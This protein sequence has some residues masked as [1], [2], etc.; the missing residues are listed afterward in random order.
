MAW[1]ASTG[2]FLVWGSTIDTNFEDGG[3]HVAQ[4][5]IVD[6]KYIFL[7]VVGFTRG[8]HVEAQASI[9][10]KLNEIVRHVLDVSLKVP[11][12]DCILIPTGGGICIVLLGRD[13]PY[14]AHVQVA[15]G[16]LARLD[17]HNENTADEMLRFEVRVGLNENR[18]NEI[19][20]ING[21][22]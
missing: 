16:I 4:A 20:D 19:T 1:S 14:D 11:E 5:N 2:A 12:N 18:D 22:R 15:F 3:G 7:D 13:A 8:R 6:A 10:E 9:V 17:A 21:H